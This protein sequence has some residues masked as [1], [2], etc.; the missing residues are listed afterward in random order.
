MKYSF[1]W[2]CKNEAIFS[3]EDN[4]VLDWPVLAII[5][6]VQSTS[7]KSC[8]SNHYRN[9]AAHIGAISSHFG[10]FTHSLVE[11]SPSTS[12]EA[13]SCAATQELPRILWNRRFIT[14]FIRAL[15]CSLS[16]TKSTQSISSHSISLRSILIFSTHLCQVFLVVSFLLAFPPI[17]CLHSASP[18]S[19]YM[20]FPSQPSWLDHSNY[21]WRR[22]QI[23]NLL[24]MQFSLFGPNILPRTLFSD[25]LS[26][27]SSLN[28]RDRVSHR[29]RLT[30]KIMVLYI[31]MFMFYDARGEDIFW[32]EW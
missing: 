31:L 28:V 27:C 4:S 30:D 3:V 18:T 32:T 8:R 14:V 5:F 16:W 10:I 2:G 12:W 7:F 9:R 20:P 29:Y 23:M 15:H 22:E 1:Q 19:R 11:L 13:A 25:T 17:F 6:F 24:I 26:L 21:T